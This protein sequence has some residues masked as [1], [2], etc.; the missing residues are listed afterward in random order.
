MEERAQRRRLSVDARKAEILAVAVALT[1]EVG[2]TGLT[3]SEIR[4]RA[5]VSTAL[6]SHYFASLDGVR[7]AVFHEIF[8]TV[9]STADESPTRRLA[10]VIGEFASTD[11]VANART[12]VD[13]LQLGRGNEAMREA[14]L[15]RMAADRDEMADIIRAGF[16]AGEF[17]GEDPE[18]SA[19]RI[20]VVLDGY[21]M[22]FLVA[23]DREVRERL[24]RVVWDLAERE[25][26][27][28]D[29]ALRS[30]AR[31]AQSH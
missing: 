12:W 30:L 18:R 23:E 13:A 22:Q 16:H 4:A 15:A 2:L 19:R 8:D 1:R 6:V 11:A 3:L 17:T 28:S 10:S 26:A 9:E 5:G 29:G 27:L 21:L 25:L 14:V 31:K 24:R 20:L 7:I